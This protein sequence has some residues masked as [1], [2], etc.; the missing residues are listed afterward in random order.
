MGLP[1]TAAYVLAISVGGPTLIEM[2]GDLLSVHLFVFF[3]AVMACVTPPVAL[4]AYAGAALAN[5]D[6]IRT[7][8]EASRIAMAGYIIPFLFVYNPGVLLKGGVGEVILAL[9]TALI[10]IYLLVW[11]LEGWMLARIK[12]WERGV[13]L[14]GAI[15][16]PFPIF[17]DNF[18]SVVL[19]LC[20]MGGF[21]LQ[22][23][24]RRGKMELQLPSS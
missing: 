19:G 10:G 13:L 16:I 15:F 20:L 6:P 8:F 3:F 4:A 21:Y 5:T 14:L 1:T 24:R 18:Q 12:T 11:G 17:L 23:K 2:G 9:L 22:Q 7:G